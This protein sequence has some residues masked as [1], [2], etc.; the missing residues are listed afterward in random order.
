MRSIRQALSGL[1]QRAPTQTSTMTINPST[2]TIVKVNQTQSL[3][4]LQT[5]VVASLSTIF[6]LR[7]LLPYHFFE[8]R[9]YSLSDPNF[10]Y[11]L[12]DHD[13]LSV[14]RQQNDKRTV[15]WDI[16]VQGK[17]AHADKVLSWLVTTILPGKG[18]S[19]NNEQDG[20]GDALKRKY[21]ATFVVCLHNGDVSSDTIAE[22]YVMKF[23]YSGPEL[24]PHIDITSGK[25]TVDLTVKDMQDMKNLSHK[26]MVL[27]SQPLGKLQGTTN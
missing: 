5:T 12:A 3:H 20:V 4:I 24:E 7:N 11:V 10:P 1:D 6:S 16:L 27:A 17:H 8:R 14:R 2:Q 22:A 15:T 13:A 9:T 18:P 26:L 21:V 19:T 23:S 25:E